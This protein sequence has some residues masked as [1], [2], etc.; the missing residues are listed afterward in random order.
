MNTLKLTAASAALFLGLSGV[1]HAT[2]DRETPRYPHGKPDG[3]TEVRQ[4]VN[5]DQSRTTIDKRTVDVDRRTYNDYREQTIDR[6]INAAGGQGGQGG[7]GGDGG[8]A[9]ARSDSRSHA[10][11]GAGGAAHA[12]GGEASSQATGGNVEGVSTGSIT[13]VENHDYP[14]PIG[15]A[16]NVYIQPTGDCGDGWSLSVGLPYSAIGGGK[17]GQDSFCIS[18]NAA[19]AAI[20]AG[21]VKGDDGLVASGFGALRQLHVEFDTAANIVVQNLIS[22]CAS[23]AAARS[24]VLLTQQDLDCSALAPR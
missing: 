23:Q 12:D 4:T 1:A 2:G 3:G 22:E 16:P 21:I 6:S 19:L 18:N 15:I 9:D 24:V 14:T 11:G 13:N 20:N 17:S 5:I 7:R 8:A 10:E